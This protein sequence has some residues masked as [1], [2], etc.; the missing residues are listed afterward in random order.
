MSAVQLQG[1]PHSEPPPPRLR[2]E[3]AS[4]LRLRDGGR[5]EAVVYCW[6]QTRLGGGRSPASSR[7]ASLYKA[8]EGRAAAQLWRSPFLS[9][10]IC[11]HFFNAGRQPRSFQLFPG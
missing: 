2:E 7:K 1:P 9:N 11:R 10:I 3:V 6:W 8:R 5:R 4:V